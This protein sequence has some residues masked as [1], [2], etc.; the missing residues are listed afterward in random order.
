[1]ISI[2][3]VRDMMP[4]VIRTKERHQRLLESIEEKIISAAKEDKIS[5]EIWVNED[6]C[7]FIEDALKLEGF[8][9]S[10]QKSMRNVGTL[11]TFNIYKVY[12]E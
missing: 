5:I 3:E 8:S 7:A 11:N 1:M 9:I 10:Y 2:Q 4:S 6:D 12:W